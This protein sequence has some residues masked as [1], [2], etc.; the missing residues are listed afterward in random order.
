MQDFIVHPSENH[1]DMLSVRKVFR[2]DQNSLSSTAFQKLPDNF[3]M[4]KLHRELL[5][6]SLE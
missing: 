6:I 2:A 3:E 4:T 1:V 5:T